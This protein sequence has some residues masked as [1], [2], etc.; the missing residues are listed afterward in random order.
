[1]VSSVD[2]KDLS[3]EVKGE[4]NKAGIAWLHEVAGAIASQTA[5]IS[6]RNTGQTAGSFDYQVDASSGVAYVGSPLENAVW[7]EK[8]TGEY[9]VEGNGRK[10]GWWIPI[11]SGKNEISLGMA[12]KYHFKIREFEGKQFAFTR[13]KKPT[14]AM[15]KAFQVIK[16][17]AEARARE[18]FGGL[19]D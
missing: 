17:K 19:N 16:P 7:E 8:G 9:A 18:V 6:R 12:K 11:G 4:L 10:G 5:S 15:T 13:G 1:M 3:I 14:L 2:F